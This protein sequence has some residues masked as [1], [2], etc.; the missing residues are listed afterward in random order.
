MGPASADLLERAA[1]VV[2]ESEQLIREARR[3]GDMLAASRAILAV[4]RDEPTRQAAHP[5]GP[6]ERQSV[7]RKGN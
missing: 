1:R 6:A 2:A 3:L 5:G 4:S 7:R